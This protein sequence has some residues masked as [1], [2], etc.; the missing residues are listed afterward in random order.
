MTPCSV[1]SL[2]VTP[3]GRSL[4]S[5][6]GRSG[7][8]QKASATPSR[9]QASRRAWPAAPSRSWRG[10]S[11]RTPSPVVISA[12]PP[13]CSSTI[14]RCR[15]GDIVPE[16]MKPTVAPVCGSTSVAP[17]ALVS[18]HR[19]HDLN[20]P[21][22]GRGP[23]TRKPTRFFSAGSPNLWWPRKP[24]SVFLRLAGGVTTG[25]HLSGHTDCPGQRSLLRGDRRVKVRAR[26][27][28]TGLQFSDRFTP[29]PQ[30][31]PRG[32]GRPERQAPRGAL[33]GCC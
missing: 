3:S 4:S 32:A 8:A 31:A 33:P 5:P 10:A 20:A 17:A 25:L 28:Q 16:V 26:E 22:T 7:S 11:Q 6:G 14:G 9:S 13:S 19:P 18:A 30:G 12:T 29:P 23:S 1:G 24:P 27:A 15:C 2:P 21:L